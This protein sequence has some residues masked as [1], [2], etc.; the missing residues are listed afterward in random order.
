MKHLILPE[1]IFLELFEY[2][3]QI[4]LYYRLFELIYQVQVQEP[5]VTGETS[6]N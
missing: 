5:K 1:L 6:P 2:P 3:P 4:V